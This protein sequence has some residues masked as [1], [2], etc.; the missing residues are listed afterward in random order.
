MIGRALGAA[1]YTMSAALAGQRLIPPLFAFL[2]AA[3]LTQ[4]SGGGI[5]PMIAETAAFVF[6]LAAWV[7]IL[8]LAPDSEAATATAEAALGSPSRLWVFRTI[9]AF[10]VS[11]GA[12]VASWASSVLSNVNS[13]TGMQSVSAFLVLGTVA[14]SGVT[15][16]SW[17]ARPLIRRPGWRVVVVLSLTVVELLPRSFPDGMAVASLPGPAAPGVGGKLLIIAIGMVGL[18]TASA[19][20]ATVVIRRVRG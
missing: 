11:L 19:S 8:L 12:V 10:I 15:V 9:T 13:V 16:G 6:P 7:S 3:S 18:A 1:R 4:V 20:L 17:C 14:L 2:F 5:R